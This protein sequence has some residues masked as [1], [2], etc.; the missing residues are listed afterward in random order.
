MLFKE[1]YYKDEAS[2]EKLLNDLKD[3]F[4]ADHDYDSAE[5]AIFIGLKRILK[6]Q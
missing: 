3:I 4:L 5:Q 1:D 2:V 6:K